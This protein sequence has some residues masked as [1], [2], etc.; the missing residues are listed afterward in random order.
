M[1]KS[2]IAAVLYQKAETIFSSFCWMELLTG[3]PIS[4]KLKGL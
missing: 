2:K 3:N 1:A 4:I